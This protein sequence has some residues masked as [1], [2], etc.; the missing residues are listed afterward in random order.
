MDVSEN[1]GTPKSSILIGVFHYK[2]SI[3]GAHPYFPSIPTT[4]RIPGNFHPFGPLGIPL[5]PGAR[6]LDLSAG[7][8]LVGLVASRF[9]AP[10][11]V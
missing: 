2:P 5:A 7:T 9:L 3:L 4:P 10:Q 11:K 8:G 1:T 6:A